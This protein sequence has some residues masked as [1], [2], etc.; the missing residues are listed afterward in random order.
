MPQMNI[1]ILTPDKDPMGA[2]ILA[3]QQTGRGGKI[4]VLSSLFDEDSIDV[5]YLFR[6]LKAMPRLEQK[7]LELSHGRVLDVGAG[8]GCHALALQD[9]LEVLAIDISPLSV[10]AMQQRGIKQCRCVNL[11]DPS[12]QERFDSILLLMNGSGIIGSLRNMPDF[13]DRMKQL[14]APGGQILLDSSDLKYLYENEDGTYD[15]DVTGEY[16]G[17]VDF[18]MVYKKVKGDSFDWLYVDFETLRMLADLNG[19]SCEKVIEGPHYDYL[20]KLQLR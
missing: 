16:Y 7:V 4:R 9:R 12:F 15:I 18:Q 17:Q 1:A 8:A 19:F 2:A 20:A 13:F 11:F 3:H 6:D 10:Q 5:P 14:L